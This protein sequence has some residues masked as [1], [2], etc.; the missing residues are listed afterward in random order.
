MGLN[1]AALVDVRFFGD[2]D[3]AWVPIRDCYLF[4][5]ADPNPATNKFKRHSIA[6]SLKV[7]K[8]LQFII[9]FFFS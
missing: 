1:S 9:I 8:H 7:R 4:S 2:H 3:R 6:D 5:E